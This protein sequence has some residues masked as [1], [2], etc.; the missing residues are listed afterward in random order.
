MAW[1][2]CR[3]PGRSRGVPAQQEKRGRPLPW[4]EVGWLQSWKR[5]RIRRNSKLL[6]IIKKLKVASWLAL[7]RSLLLRFDAVVPGGVAL[8]ASQGACFQGRISVHFMRRLLLFISCLL[9]ALAGA[10]DHFNLARIVVA[11]SQRYQPEDVVRA[12]GLTVNT[13][14]TA[15]H[16]IG[17]AQ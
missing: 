13:Q 2:A 11:G 14:A 3:I 16:Q 5:H 10:A 17:R 6:R 7:T 8:E 4:A 15:D 1:Q 12:T 9:P